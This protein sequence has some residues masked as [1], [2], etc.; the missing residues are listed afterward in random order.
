MVRLLLAPFYS[1]SHSSTGKNLS[2]MQS[3]GCTCLLRQTCKENVQELWLQNDHFKHWL[4][5]VSVNLK[6]WDKWSMFAL[7]LTEMHEKWYSSSKNCNN[8]EST[9]VPCFSVHYWPWKLNLSVSEF[10][11]CLR[12]VETGVFNCT[13]IQVGLEKLV[14]QQL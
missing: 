1:F 7:I 8:I 12:L 5:F 4:L 3:P 2:L 9:T 10:D 14:E 6:I 13:W 11:I